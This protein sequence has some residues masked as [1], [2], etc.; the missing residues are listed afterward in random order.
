[1]LWAVTQSAGLWLLPAYLYF[2]A[3]SIALA[4]VDL[5]T[6]TL[7]NRIVVPSLVVAPAL[8]A[9]AS[10]GTGDWWA[11]LWA[12]VGGGALFL[13]Y[14]ILVLAYPQG[15]GFGDVK[16]AALVGLYLAYLG[17]GPLIVGAFGAF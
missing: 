5:D 14:F 10:L 4:L 11:L 3:V 8:L 17:W 7:P 16:L 15:M 2:A 13:F 6:R 12:L 1:V 9:L